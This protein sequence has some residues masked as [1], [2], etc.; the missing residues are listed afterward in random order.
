MTTMNHD[1][2]TDDQ[3]DAMDQVN[4]SGAVGSPA[5]LKILLYLAHC[6]R[7]ATTGDI[8]DLLNI[9]KP[10]TLYLLRR[11][12]ADARVAHGPYKAH[13]PADWYVPAARAAAN[14]AESQAAYAALAAGNGSSTLG[15]GAANLPSTSL[16]ST[17]SAAATAIGLTVRQPRATSPGSLA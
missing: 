9:T 3:A 17:D 14:A 10:D 16:P 2:T 7:G 1:Q 6:P 15:S 8:A 13:H 4:L 5:R 12:M 11:L